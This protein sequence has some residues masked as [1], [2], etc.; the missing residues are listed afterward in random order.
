V[1]DALAAR[2]IECLVADPLEFVKSPDKGSENVLKRT[3]RKIRIGLKK[4]SD[5]LR[6]SGESFANLSDRAYAEALGEF[7]EN[8][9][10]DGIVAAGLQATA[11]CSSLRRFSVSDLPCVSLVTEHGDT[12]YAELP[13]LDL[14]CTPHRDSEISKL[15]PEEK[16]V[17]TG[18]PVPDLFGRSFDRYAARNYLVIPKSKTV[19]FINSVGL[20]K[21]T[22]Y[23][24]C[25]RLSGRAADQT[26]YVIT[27]R[28]YEYVDAV[29]EAC[30]G[31]RGVQVTAFTKK[32]FVYMKAADVIISKPFG[33]ISTAS[34]LIGVPLV[35]IS[36]FGDVE[37]AEAHFFS[38]HEMAVTAQNARDA[39]NM[40]VRFVN[41]RALAE[42][43]ST[44]QALGSVPNAAEL[45]A[46]AI[47]GCFYGR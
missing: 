45:A 5:L 25:Q 4:E 22:L 17:V 2:G 3:G 32:I 6:A 26:V 9:E 35:H 42:R 11:A 24:L 27:G 39:M 19:F 47:I 36:P 15:I 14:Y 7:A 8:G 16:Q 37:T 43:V 30:S 44:M 21:N 20:S 33:M 18:V 10:F 38:R 41:E 46:D 13:L 1:R 29:A 28:D 12:R 34:A 40:A 31:L 23:E